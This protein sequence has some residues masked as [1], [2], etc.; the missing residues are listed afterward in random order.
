MLSVELVPGLTEEVHPGTLSLH[1][2]QRDGTSFGAGHHLTCLP[3]LGAQI[4]II[5]GTLNKMNEKTKDFS[6]MEGSS[7]IILGVFHPNVL[8]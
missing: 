7:W 1:S 3:M 6:K 5:S 2:H 8:S 4:G